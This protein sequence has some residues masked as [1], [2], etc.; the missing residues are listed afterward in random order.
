[1][2]SFAVQVMDAETQN[3]LQHPRSNDVECIHHPTT[4]DKI[5]VVATSTQKNV[6]ISWSDVES[7]DSKMHLL[8]DSSD[9]NSDEGINQG[10]NLAST[11]AL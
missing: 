10:C 8:G 7:N 6:V 3:S 4:M 9:G 2:V 11:V 1:M 5:V